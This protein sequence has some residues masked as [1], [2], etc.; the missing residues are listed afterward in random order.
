MTA[1]LPSS[2]TCVPLS[3]SLSVLRNTFFSSVNAFGA[4]GP[5]FAAEAGL[6]VPAERRPV[7]DRGMRVDAQVARLD[8]R[9]TRNARPRSRVKIDP[10]S[11]YSVSL[12]IATASA[13]STNG[14]TASTGP[15]TSSRQTLLAAVCRPVP[16][17]AQ[18]VAR[19]G[20]HVPGERDLRLVGSR[21]T[22]SRWPAEISGPISAVRPRPGC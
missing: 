20:G 22:G 12:A 13:S 1:T 3:T 5:D 2:A 17:G 11:P 15:N 7:A 16:P 6:L 4:S 14:S 10:D 19:P 8:A 9:A 18:P 21:S